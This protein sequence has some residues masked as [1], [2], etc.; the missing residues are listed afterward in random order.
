MIWTVIV[1]EFRSIYNRESIKH[2]HAERKRRLIEEITCL[3][4]KQERLVEPSLNVRE[5]M[6]RRH[7]E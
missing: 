4:G 7:H 5:V 6:L 2:G 1:P 3:G